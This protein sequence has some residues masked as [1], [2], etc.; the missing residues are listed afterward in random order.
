V[1]TVRSKHES[2]PSQVD[3]TMGEAKKATPLNISNQEFFN[4][5]YGKILAPLDELGEIPEDEYMEHARRLYKETQFMIQDA[6]LSNLKKDYESTPWGLCIDTD[7]RIRGAFRQSPCSDIRAALTVDVKRWAMERALR[8]A[9]REA[10]KI[11]GEAFLKEMDIE[12]EFIRGMRHERGELLAREYKYLGKN[13]EYK[14]AISQIDKLEEKLEKLVPGRY[15]YLVGE[16]S[17]ARNTLLSLETEA[18]YKSG[19]MDGAGFKKMAQAWAGE[20]EL[21]VN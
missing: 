14:A 20:K 5:L 19:F 3:N 7:G 15:E 18:A 17:D 11:I 21:V 8:I 1:N 13:P 9:E 2:N 4:D 12:K 16:L 10:H 6:I